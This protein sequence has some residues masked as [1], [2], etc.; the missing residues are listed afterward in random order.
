VTFFLGARA[1]RLTGEG[2]VAGIEAE[3]NGETV[4]I[5]ARRG[6]VLASGDV[7]ADAAY[8]ARFQPA[9]AGIAAINPRSTGD[10]HAMA[11]ARGS[12]I[13]NGDLVAGPI[14]RFPLPRGRALAHAV[15]PTPVVGRVARWWLET[16]PAPLV[17]PALMRFLTVMLAPS[18][19]LIARGAALIDRAGELVSVDL[20]NPMNAGVAL[21]RASGGEGHFVL[22]ARL[23]AL[24]DTP[25]CPVS[26]GPGI[27]GAHL[28]DYRRHRPDVVAAAPDAAALARRLGVDPARL[29]AA[30]AAHPPFRDGVPPFV[31]L[32]P[33]KP[34]MLVSEASLPVSPGMEV[35]DAFGAPI[36]GLFA[37]GSIG[38]GGLI[39]PAHGQHIAW[40]F[41]SGRIAGKS[42]AGRMS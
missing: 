34:L 12:K 20:A 30:L 8:R 16:M 31:A 19:A 29:S 40:A 4:E 33:V 3:R 10:G 14:L 13:L 1:R 27:A 6:V 37:A 17:R 9:L 21:A 2:A 5:A 41:V 24:F 38:Q 11:E 39:L 25:A 32:G 23:A 26:G 28:R 18:P 42:A 22:D 7:S 35:L 36:P 15:P